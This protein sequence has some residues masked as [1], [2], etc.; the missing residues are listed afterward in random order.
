MHSNRWICCLLLSFVLVASNAVMARQDQDDKRQDESRHS[1]NG[2]RRVYDPDHKDY[3][4]WDGQ[5]DQ[6]WRQYLSEHHKKYRDYSH[7][8]KRDQSAYWNERH[9]NDRD[10]DHRDQD[11]RSERDDHSH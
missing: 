11:H 8:S 4:N 7:A 3:H 5:E 10:Q 9:Q 2:N 1:D 6:D